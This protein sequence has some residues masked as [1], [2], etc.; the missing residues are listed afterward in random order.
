M[1]GTFRTALRKLV[2]ST[3]RRGGDVRS[4]AEYLMSL[5]RVPQLTDFSRSRHP[6]L[7]IHGF[8]AARRVLQILEHRLRNDGYDVFSFKLGGVLDTFNTGGLES[9]ARLVAGKIERLSARYDLPKIDVVAHSAGGII[10]RHWVKRLEGHRYVRTIVTLGTPHNGTPF[11]YLG[12]ALGG[13]VSRS[14]WQLT[15][16]SGFIRRL[17]KGP[18]PVQTRIVSIYST[19]DRL[20]P[21]PGCVLETDGP[22]IKN[23]E[24]SDY[25]HTDFLTRK[26]IYELVLAELEADPASR[27]FPDY[28]DDGPTVIDQDT[29]AG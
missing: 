9:A 15:P 1:E 28:P 23:I 12:V 25:S 3:L 11:A 14:V 26:D 19:A 5:N 29:S 22:N 17:K 13:A 27:E 16:M 20:C 4:Y 21:H 6:V 10:A 24:L 8:A 2:R 7:L 18:F